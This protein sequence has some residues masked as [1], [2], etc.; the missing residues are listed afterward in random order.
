MFLDAH[1]TVI[2]N[3]KEKENDDV[4]NVNDHLDGHIIKHATLTRL[5]EFDQLPG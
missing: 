5:R 2:Q 1:V 4:R 3:V